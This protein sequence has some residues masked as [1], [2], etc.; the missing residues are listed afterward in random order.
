[1]SE[2]RV[3]IFSRSGELRVID[4]STVPHHDGLHPLM[5]LAAAVLDAGYTGIAVDEL[6]LQT[7]RILQSLEVDM[8]TPEGQIFKLLSEIS[9]LGDELPVP[10]TVLDSLELVYLFKKREGQS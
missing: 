9:E 7:G 2:S 3:A 10:Q 8:A 4:P 1:M 5:Q 6:K